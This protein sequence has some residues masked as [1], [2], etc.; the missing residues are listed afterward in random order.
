MPRLRAAILDTKRRAD[1]MIVHNARAEPEDA[2][3]HLRSVDDA[4]QRLSKEADTYAR[5]QTILRLTRTDFSQLHELKEDVSLKLR[6]WQSV[7]DWREKME[8]WLDS[9]FHKAIDPADMRAQMRAF[10]KFAAVAGRSTV[11]RSSPVLTMLRA[12]LSEVKQLAPV[13]GDLKNTSLQQSHK[14]R[15]HGLLGGFRLFDEPIVLVGTLVEKG[16]THKSAE[17]SQV[18]LEATQEA[19][20]E[21][22]LDRIRGVWETKELDTI[23][24]KDLR[25]VEILT[26]VDDIFDALDESFVSLNSVLGSRFVGR[27]RPKVDEL[28]TRLHQLQETLGEWVSV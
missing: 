13:L 15:I 12:L 22:V 10:S 21:T 8:Q 23:P 1:E 20:L 4:V 18:A 19:Q 7:R 2:I 17:I 11:L 25:D 26:G 14:E 6:L 27:I 28:A 9:D 16:V 3:G 5:Y 24:Y